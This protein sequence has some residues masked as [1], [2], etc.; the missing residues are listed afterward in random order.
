[1]TEEGKPCFHGNSWSLPELS[2][3]QCSLCF[4]DKHNSDIL[5]YLYVEPAHQ[6]T[7]LVAVLLRFDFAM[8]LPGLRP[9]PSHPVVNVSIRL[10]F[11]PQSPHLRK[12]LN[13]V[14]KAIFHLIFS[15]YFIF[16]QYFLTVFTVW[17]VQ[18]TAWLFS[19][20]S[21]WTFIPSTIA[22]FLRPKARAWRHS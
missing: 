11:L 4:N 9:G 3:N 20:L 14:K 8:L 21:V 1:M 7:G 22:N 12:F 17:G 18:I 6:D 2:I 13:I 10:N 16:R 5:S 15:S 19:A